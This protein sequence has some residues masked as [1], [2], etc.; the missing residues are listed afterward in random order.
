MN[1]CYSAKQAK[2]I[3]TLLYN[4]DLDNEN[5]Q[6]VKYSLRRTDISDMTLE[7]AHRII[8][9]MPHAKKDAANEILLGKI[10]PLIPERYYMEKNAEQLSKS[11][12]FNILMVVL[13]IGI[14]AFGITLA[15]V[16]FTGIWGFVCGV[17]KFILPLI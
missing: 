1:I 13:T 8:D 7:E 10:K 3:K 11:L 4:Q 5:I 17:F 12:W 6:L 2:A 14:V 9:K 15:C 16:A